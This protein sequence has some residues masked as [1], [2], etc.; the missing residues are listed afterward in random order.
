MSLLWLCP[1]RIAQVAGI[2]YLLWQL[3]LVIISLLR[4]CSGT[5]SGWVVT[6]RTATPTAHFGVPM[7]VDIARDAEAEDDVKGLR[8]TFSGAEG[9]S[10]LLA[11]HG[12][13]LAE[14]AVN[15]GAGQASNDPELGGCQPSNVV[16]S[17]T[18]CT[19]RAVASVAAAS[20]T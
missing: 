3:L 17:D 13:L 10:P 1:P 15:G 19:H 6:Q 14:R 7:N 4:I 9:L 12:V 16:E 18:G 20:Q 2:P 8:H 11:S 5:D